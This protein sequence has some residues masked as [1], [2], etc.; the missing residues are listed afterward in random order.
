M[1]HLSTAGALALT[2]LGVASISGCNQQQPQQAPAQVVEKETTVVH[3]QPVIV[4][5]DGNRPD[6]DH[7]EAPPP[8]DRR[9]TPPPADHHDDR[10]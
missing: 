7:R 6:V 8:A 9:D 2:T 1:K 4:R 10:H 3:D 5:Q